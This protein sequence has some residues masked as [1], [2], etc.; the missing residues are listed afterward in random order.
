MAHSPDAQAAGFHKTSGLNQTCCGSIPYQYAP[1]ETGRNLTLYRHCSE[2]NSVT[3]KEASTWSCVDTA[4]VH[5]T[6][7]EVV[8]EMLAVEKYE[9]QNSIIEQLS[10]LLDDEGIESVNIARTIQAVNTGL[11]HMVSSV[12]PIMVACHYIRTKVISNFTNKVQLPD[13]W[14]LNMALADG[15]DPGQVTEPSQITLATMLLQQF[16]GRIPKTRLLK[17]I[18]ACI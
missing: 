11:R 2:D 16:S 14:R 18:D 5:Q 13:S 9:K 7:L 6:A 3:P 1:A 4:Q 17:L 15:N 12:S 10:R 8:K